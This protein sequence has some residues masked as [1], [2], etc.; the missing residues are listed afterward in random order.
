[1]I[2]FKYICKNYAQQ[3]F[4]YTIN[5]ILLIQQEHINMYKWQVIL[6]M[7]EIV[8]EIC[9]QSCMHGYI[10]GIVVTLMYKNYGCSIINSQYQY[11][12]KYC[13]YVA[14]NGDGVEGVFFL[15]FIECT[16][17]TVLLEQF[18]IKDLTPLLT[19]W[20]WRVFWRMI[21]KYS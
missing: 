2:P 13:G 10:W 12:K 20:S 17:M 18:A 7:C 21:I 6:T 9:L 11:Y 3:Y 15:I 5:C 4:K 16:S 19:F 1:M 8:L 14:C